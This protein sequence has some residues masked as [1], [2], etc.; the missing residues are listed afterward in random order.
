MSQTNVTRK[1]HVVSTGQMAASVQEADATSVPF[2]KL[3][4]G[5]T[6]QGIRDSL[7]DKAFDELCT[8]KGFEREHEPFHLPSKS[9]HLNIHCHTY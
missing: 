7:N 1:G 4:L 3:G 2:A 8:V 5:I 6:V 9:L